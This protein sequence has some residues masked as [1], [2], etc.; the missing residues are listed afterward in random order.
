MDRLPAQDPGPISS[1]PDARA[2]PLERSKI[3]V[4]GNG[5][6][7]KTQLRRWLLSTPEYP[8]PFDPQNVL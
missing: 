3:I 4:L 1:Y 8:Q 5:Q 2:R 7:G 6:V